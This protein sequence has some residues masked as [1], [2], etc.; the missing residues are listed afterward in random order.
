MN[1]TE[2][3]LFLLP[4]SALGILYFIAER[5]YNIRL[6]RLEKIANLFDSEEYRNYRCS[7]TESS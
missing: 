1:E 6:K 4:F 7:K 2:I 3:I 5:R